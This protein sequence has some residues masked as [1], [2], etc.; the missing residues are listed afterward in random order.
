L[1]E[2]DCVAIDTPARVAVLGA[3]PIGLEAALYA[4]FLGYDVAVL[5]RGGVAENVRRWGHVRM[6]SPFS[7]NSTRL[8]LAAIAAQDETYQAP[9]K[10]AL[11]TGNQ[12]ADRY[13]VPLSQ[14]DLLAD[15]LQLQTEVIAISRRNWLKHERVGSED[16]ADSPF[17][18]LLRHRDG[19]ESIES[20]DAV[21]DATGVFG[22]PNSCGP[23]GAPA[24]GERSLRDRIRYD[25]PDV[26]DTERAR[27]ARKTV[28]VI[29]R[30]YSAA[31]S[32]VALAELARRV[33]SGSIIWITRGADGEEP[34]PPLR[35][36]SQ[37]PLAERV[38]LIRQ[39]N[40]LA[41]EGN[42]VC[43]WPATHVQQI[44]WDAGQSRFTVELAGLHSG[45]IDVDEI[46]ANVGYHPDASIYAQ[47]QVHECYATGGPMKLAARLAA[48]SGPGDCLQQQS[49]GVQALVC[50]EPDFYI[51]GAKSY[52]RRS[53]FLV[54]VGYQQIRELFTLIGDREGLDLYQGAAQLPGG[55]TE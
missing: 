27:Y 23:G 47:L 8:G 16:R 49:H 10:D 38:R 18:L 50:P 36:I 34:R 46:I 4:R 13:L 15:H 11:L 30:G 24:L 1:D 26:A 48:D 3:G 12:W 39:A 5:D 25:L 33:G 19:R 35:E 14:T 9:P 21:I 6:F 45:P 55:R 52:G 7:R 20:A 29:G 53:D 43:H 51:L 22:Q 2:V 28:L 42:P 17:Y 32:V 41:A 31:T 44:A 54:S 37:D 40:Q